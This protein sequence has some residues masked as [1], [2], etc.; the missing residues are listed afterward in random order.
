MK[1]SKQFIKADAIKWL[2]KNKGLGSVIAS[3]PDAEDVGLNIV[4]WIDWFENATEKTLL[5]TK[6][7]T[8]TIFMVTDRKH[9]KQVISKANMIFK[10]AYKLNYKLQFH[11]I[12]LRLPLGTHDI[13]R[14]AYTHVLAFNTVN[15]AKD[16]NV[17]GSDVFHRG[18][19][20][21]KDATGIDAAIRMVKY[22][23]NF[24]DTIVNPFSGS[25]TICHIAEKYG[26]NSIGIEILESQIDLANKV[27]IK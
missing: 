7:D 4:E 21:Y 11:K 27:V 9:D 15:N 2:E 1:P 13:F 19:T 26:F 23:G 10:V 14:P 3:P 22:A 24:S 18:K 20:I 16:V 5:A 25:G 12:A 8:P 6:K 17:Q